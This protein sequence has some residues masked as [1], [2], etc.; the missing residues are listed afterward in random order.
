MSFKAHSRKQKNPYLLNINI[1]ED[2]T[3]SGASPM[4]MMVTVVWFDMMSKNKS[5]NFF[6]QMATFQPI[7]MYVT[8]TERPKTT[9]LNAKKVLFTG[10]NVFHPQ[11]LCCKMCLP[12][13]YSLILYPLNRN[14]PPVCQVYRAKWILWAGEQRL[15]PAPWEMKL[16]ARR[17]QLYPCGLHYTSTICTF[18]RWHRGTGRLTGPPRCS[19]AL[20]DSA[21]QKVLHYMQKEGFLVKHKDASNI[22]QMIQNQDHLNAKI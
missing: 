17:L 9:S 4:S 2:A 18:I 21:E 1:D 16:S 10:T 11:S 12:L 3:P 13:H 6:L 14:V 20:T 15:P 5:L 22:S 8:Y 7:C 19:L